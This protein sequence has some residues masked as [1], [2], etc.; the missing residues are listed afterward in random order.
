MKDEEMRRLKRQ[1]DLVEKEFASL[2]IAI[3]SA[4]TNMSKAVTTAALKFPD[5]S[6][7]NKGIEHFFTEE[8]LYGA[9]QSEASPSKKGSEH[10]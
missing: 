9:V 8:D 10:Y 2:R 4:C 3:W 6:P 5:K 7:S 1:L